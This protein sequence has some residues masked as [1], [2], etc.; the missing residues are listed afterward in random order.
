M[1]GINVEGW[2]V[3]RLLVVGVGRSCAGLTGVGVCK[4]V[5]GGLVVH[6]RTWMDC[7]FL[8]PD[9]LLMVAA[10]CG[11]GENWMVQSWWGHRLAADGGWHSWHVHPS[12]KDE[13]RCG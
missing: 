11:A 10:L 9:S 7:A 8:P 13:L 6:L 1:A 4:C 2:W 3:L 12:I 5:G